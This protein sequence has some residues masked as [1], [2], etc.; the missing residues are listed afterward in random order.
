MNFGILFKKLLP[1]HSTL[2]LYHWH[3]ISILDNRTSQNR[4][5]LPIEK[6][7]NAIPRLQEWAEHFAWNSDSTKVEGLTA[8]GR[9]MTIALRMNNAIIVSAR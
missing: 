5:I 2:N 7:K 3:L 4:H 6:V 8:I 1:F 9:A